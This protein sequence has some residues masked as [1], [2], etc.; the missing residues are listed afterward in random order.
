MTTVGPLLANVTVKWTF[1]TV[2][3]R[4]IAISQQ[5]AN[6]GLTVLCDLGYET[7]WTT[8]VFF[9]NEKL[10]FFATSH[11]EIHTQM[12]Q[13]LWFFFIYHQFLWVFEMWV[14]LCDT[15]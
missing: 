6:A 4:G 9:C 8:F 10:I 2:G 13:L 14:D 7:L 5:L 15:R 11:D 1:Q 3:Q 12:W